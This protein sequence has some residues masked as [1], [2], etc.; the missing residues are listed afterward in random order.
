LCLFS[1][2]SAHSISNAN[3]NTIAKQSVAAQTASDSG[4]WG[5]AV[6][7]VQLHL[8][9]AK[10]LPTLPGELPH[11]EIQIRNMGNGDVVFNFETINWWS[12]IEIDGVWYGPAVLRNPFSRN[13]DPGHDPRFDRPALTPGQQS[14]VIPIGSI[15]SHN[16]LDV[17]LSSGKHTIRIKTPADVRD[18][19]QT[20]TSATSRKEVKLTSNAI[21]IET[22]AATGVG[23][24]RGSIGPIQQTPEADSWGEPVDGIQLGL[25]ISQDASALLPVFLPY[26]EMQIRNMGTHT[27][28]YSCYLGQTAQT[29]ID[30]VW[31]KPGGFV[32]TA[33]C[34]PPSPLAPGTRTGK[35]PLSLR[36]YVGRQIVPFDKLNLTPGKHSIR[37][38]AS[39]GDFPV[40]TLVSNALGVEIPDV[41]PVAETHPFSLAPAHSTSTTNSHAIAKQSSTP[42]ETESQQAPDVAASVGEIASAK[43]AANAALDIVQD[44]LRD[45]AYVGPRPPGNNPRSGP[46]W[47]MFDLLE[48]LNRAAR[49][50]S[51][52]DGKNPASME[53]KEAAFSNALQRAIRN[54]DAI[55]GRA[56]E[57][58]EA[59]EKSRALA[60]RLRSIS[61]SHVT[62]GA[63]HVGGPQP[64]PGCCVPPPPLQTQGPAGPP[65]LPG[66]TGPAGPTGPSGPAGPQGPPGPAGESVV[67]F[68]GIPDFSTQSSVWNVPNGGVQGI[69]PCSTNGKGS[70][71]SLLSPGAIPGSVVSANTIPSFS[72]ANGTISLETLINTVDFSNVAEGDFAAVGLANGADQNNA[73]EI[74]GFANNGGGSLTCRTVS[75]GAT[76]QT[77]ILLTAPQN[78]SLYQYEIIATTSS[79]QFYVNGALVATHTT[80]IPTMPLNAVFLVS[81][82]QASSNGQYPSLYVSTTTFRQRP[83]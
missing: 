57:R 66:A 24:W 78:T 76:T 40:M 62:K 29:E 38:R 50:V 63:A 33:S 18:R 80:D 23:K 36:F 42:S 72:L 27:V 14:M 32:V 79:V 15:V 19:F 17:A 30:G 53:E 64:P 21:T 41:S 46:H 7:G 1:S 67:A 2:A 59:K 77:N 82:S 69:V 10:N 13:A 25:D 73:I 58:E 31:Y 47:G 56:D 22:T 55:A 65:G 9:V 6:D 8:A 81:T 5:D 3:S 35:I 44:T 49:A 74:V 37:V 34:H 45:T 51:D 75:G 48:N 11:F 26:L 60:T 52:D 43:K 28:N 16:G 68:S 12:Q 70:E 39:V 20:A 54:A 61:Y 83:Q 4:A 71:C